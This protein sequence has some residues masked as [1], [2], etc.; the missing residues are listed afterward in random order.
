MGQYPGSIHFPTRELLNVRVWSVEAKMLF[1]SLPGSLST[2]LGWLQ[3]ACT[4]IK[5]GLLCDKR[6]PLELILRKL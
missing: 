6:L 3:P 2:L 5:R 1:L 4:L